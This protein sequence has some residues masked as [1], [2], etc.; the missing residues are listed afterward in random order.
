[1]DTTNI[2][3]HWITHFEAKLTR[4]RPGRGQML[5]ADRDQLVGAKAEAEATILDSRP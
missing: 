3:S 4:P 1:M 5:E 2:I